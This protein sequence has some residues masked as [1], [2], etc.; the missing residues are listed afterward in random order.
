VAD[1]E[2]EVVKKDAD[3]MPELH[4]G[5]TAVSRAQWPAKRTGK[6]EATCDVGQV[7]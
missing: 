7:E 2:R 3:R 5:T 4:Q 6:I 1:P